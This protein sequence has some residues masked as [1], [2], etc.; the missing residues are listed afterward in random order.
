MTVSISVTGDDAIVR[1]EADAKKMQDFMKGKLG[2]IFVVG[3]AGTVLQYLLIYMFVIASSAL[4]LVLFSALPYGY[5]DVIYRALADNYEYCLYVF[6]AAGSLSVMLYISDARFWTGWWHVLRNVLFSVALAGYCVAVLLATKAFVVAPIGLFLFGSPVVFMV[7]KR[8]CF[9]HM[10][11]VAYLTAVRHGLL[12]VFVG[13][14]GIWMAWLIVNESYWDVDTK[15]DFYERMQCNTTII[16]FFEPE[17]QTAEGQLLEL[18]NLNLTDVELEVLNSLLVDCTSGFILW[19]LPF[20]QSLWAFVFAGVIFFVVRTLQRA[21][22]AKD[23]RA[24]LDPL[25]Q[26]FL[27]F[28]GL[29]LLGMWAA[30]GIAGTEMD[31]T[32][33]ILGL[34]FLAMIISGLLIVATFGWADV[35]DG[36]GRTPLG[37]RMLAVLGSDWIRAFM[38]M[39]ASPFFLGYLCLSVLTQTS[40]KYFRC[41]KAIDDEERKYFFTANAS[42]FLR[43]VLAWNWSS[44]L[45]K[46]LWVGVIFFTIVV[47]VTRLTTLFLSWLNQVLLPVSLIVTTVSFVAVGITMFLLPPVPGVPVYVAGGVILVSSARDSLGFYGAILLTLAVCFGLKLSAIAIQQK[48]IGERYGSKRVYIRKLIGVNSIETRAIRDILMQ[49]GLNVAKVSIL[50]GGPDWPT[51][52]TTGILRLPLSSMIIGSLPVFFLITPCVLAGAFLLRANEGGIWESVSTLTLAFA[53]VVQSGAMLA[54][55]HFIAKT[56]VDKEDELRNLPPDEEVLE[57]ERASHHRTQL[58]RAVSHWRNLDIVNKVL[59]VIASLSMTASCYLFQLFGSSCFVLFEVDDSIDDVLGGDALNLVKDLGWIALG[60]FLYPCFY[61]F[62]F[63]KYIG[64]LVSIVDKDEAEQARLLERAGLEPGTKGTD[65][66]ASGSA[67]T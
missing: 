46:T 59:L 2:A 19:L 12:V 20:I 18:A 5:G 56:V 58:R 57:L 10:D 21:R 39:L 30:A 11:L 64:R 4:F 38:L 50:C 34:A 35:M 55:I 15:L 65:L 42:R 37:S 1:E 23:Q 28:I 13:S 41:T 44:V 67:S 48:L 24:A 47:G 61:L 53:F 33:I 27:M 62:L 36:M 63:N 16:G 22:N 45:V 31:L 54:A 3:S 52:V 66:A 7:L 17:S 60:L 14:L 8:T 49:P 26:F 51:S 40:R 43:R 25:A 9:K 32:N 6:G 29:G